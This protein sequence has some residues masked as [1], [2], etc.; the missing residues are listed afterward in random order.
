MKNIKRLL[1][2]AM[3]GVIGFTA[4]GCSMIEKTPEAIKNTV[5]AKV[6]GEKITKGDVDQELTSYINQFKQTYGENFE[7][8]ASIKAQLDEYRKQ[9][10]ENLIDE[11]VLL[12]KAKELNLIPSDEDLKKEID[13]KIASL[14]EMYGSKE[15]L[16]EAKKSFGY[17]DE[18]FNEFIKNQ[19]ISQKTIDYLYK[20]VT[21]TDEDIQKNYD[22]N[23]DKAYTK[24]AGATMYH[25]L[26]DT[27][28][29]AADVKKRLDNGESFADLAKEF[30]A[31]STKDTGGS[32][33]FVEYSTESFD[34]DFMA[35]AKELKEGEISGPVK[36]QFGYHIIKVDG[37]K[38]EKAVQSLDEVKDSIKS[39]LES[40]KKQETYTSKMEEWK[41]ELDVKKYL[42]KL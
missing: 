24:D 33:G 25:I 23:K 28:E 12:V 6:N 8:D 5:L 4:M 26:V 7:E 10:I 38:S 42:D 17:N 22:E 39:E 3:I 20:D 36:T 29:K 16:E 27:E 40:T 19:V 41:K 35:A 32:L 2:T 18:T 1:A 15:K 30:N 37:V 21:V 34:K 14:E 31:D 11:K 9:V 13:E